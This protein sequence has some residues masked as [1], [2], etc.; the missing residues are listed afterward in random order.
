MIGESIGM[1]ISEKDNL[2]SG[3]QE[4]SHFLQQEEKEVE[5]KQRVEMKN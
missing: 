5:E 3:A 4:Y 1:E 2:Q